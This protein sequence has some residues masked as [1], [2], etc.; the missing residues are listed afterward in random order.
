MK[1]YTL[2]LIGKEL[3]LQEDEALV[4]KQA[5]IKGNAPKYIEI[6]DDLINTSQIMGIFAG[7]DVSQIKQLQEVPMTEEQKENRRK[8]LEEMRKKWGNN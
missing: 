4:L 2:K 6:G 1:N 3:T 5:L 7:D 8:V